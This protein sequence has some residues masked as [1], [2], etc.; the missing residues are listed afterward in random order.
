MF[1]RHIPCLFRV[2]AL[3]LPPTSAGPF[4]SPDIERSSSSGALAG[5]VRDPRFGSGRTA[6]AV[7]RGEATGPFE[8][9]L[10]PL[11]ETDSRT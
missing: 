8:T 1:M 2:T 6:T 3:Y 10:E 7:R 9:G 11:D 5:A 4:Q